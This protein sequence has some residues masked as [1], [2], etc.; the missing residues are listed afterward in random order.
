MKKDS[1]FSYIAD[2]MLAIGSWF[3]FMSLFFYIVPSKYNV[4][5]ILTMIGILCLGFCG[6]IIKMKNVYLAYTAMLL[7]IIALLKTIFF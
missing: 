6:V 3:I 1:K 2:L 7:S 4:S 5:P